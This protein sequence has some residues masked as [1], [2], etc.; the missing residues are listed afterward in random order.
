[1]L[2][3]GIHSPTVWAGRHPGERPPRGNP[4]LPD[5]VSSN[6]GWNADD[7]EDDEA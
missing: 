2:R 6:A 7:D 5:R 4:A 3:T 1:M